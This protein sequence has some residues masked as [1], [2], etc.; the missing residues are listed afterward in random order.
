[1]PPRLEHKKSRNGCQRCKTRKV[2]CSE[3]RPACNSCARHGVDCIYPSAK[4]SSS[5][6][7]AV[8]TPSHSTAGSPVSATS[9]T[10]DTSEPSFFL[11]PS[12]A[13]SISPQFGA[14]TQESFARRVLELR[15]LSHFLTV[16]T[17]TFNG[18]DNPNIL[19]AW[20]YRLPALALR[21]PFLLNA[22]LATA[23]LN[24]AVAA[25]SSAEASMAGEHHGDRQGVIDAI[26]SG[27]TRND[28]AGIHQMYLDLSLSEHRAAINGLSAENADAV[29][30]TSVLI[31]NHGFLLGSRRGYRS[32]AETTVENGRDDYEVPLH[33]LQLS[34]GIREIVYYADDD[35]LQPGSLIRVLMSTFNW[36]DVNEAIN[37][38]SRPSAFSYL[39]DFERYQEPTH[40][41]LE[42]TYADF[43]TEPITAR[44]IYERTVRYLG[45]IYTSIELGMKLQ[46]VSRLC[47]GF[48]SMVPRSFTK[49]VEEHRPRA[50]ACLAHLF[51]LTVVLDH[52][53]WFQGAARRHVE[54]LES[55]V[56]PEWSWAM[57]WPRKALKGEGW[58]QS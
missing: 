12:A 58:H 4:P 13:T 36:S 3:H 9:Q 39:I 27:M 26:R 11:P 53:W 31:G 21:F 49:L 16:I 20:Q 15:L 41:S 7:L 50:L 33:W 51:A 2:K 40:F 5:L 45:H 17:T 46:T 19:E 30:M 44:E 37:K 24:L 54:G 42:A 28:F 25:D 38:S 35:L 22:L 55:K 14:A 57:E 10:S 34:A 52:I 18:S 23:A 48:G 6:A 8:P 47:M 29:C 56:G 43:G 1:M 32:T